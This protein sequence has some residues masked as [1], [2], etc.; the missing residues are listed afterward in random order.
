LP[1]F[2]PFAW[3]STLYTVGTKAHAKAGRDRACIEKAID[4]L[5]AENHELDRETVENARRFIRFAER[6][7]CPPSEVCR[8][9]WPAISDDLKLILDASIPQAPTKPSTST[10]A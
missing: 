5:A 9:Y 6:R 1:G 2:Q 4:T 8:G 10:N 7:Y 3:R